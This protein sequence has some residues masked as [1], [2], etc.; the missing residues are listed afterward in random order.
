MEKPKIATRQEWTL[1]RRA[2]L[3]KEKA[4]TRARDALS[5]ERRAL[6]WV[7]I[8]KEYAFDGPRG[9]VSLADL[10]AGRRQ[11]VVYHL[12]FDPS[13]AEACKS[14]S[15]VVDHFAGA[16]PHLAARDTA[17]CAVSRAG[18]PTIEAFKRRMGWTF[19]WV[20]SASSDF[21]Y[22]FHVSFH[23]GDAAAGRAEYNYAKTERDSESPGASAFI[24]D[25]GRIFH[26]YST[27]GRGLDLLIGTYNYLD[28]TPLG[29]DEGKLEWPMQWVRHHDKYPATV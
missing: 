13:W 22:D 9:P 19:P 3:E 28:L 10:F 4:F 23:P 24:R 26:T 1:A 6:P 27:Y 14:C 5:A 11:L 21:N 8:D 15:Y 7:L 17:L 29:R 16:I 25:D 18:V 20:S 12:M 2:L